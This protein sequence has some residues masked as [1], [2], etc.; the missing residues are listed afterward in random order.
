M[1]VIKTLY[2]SLGDD[3]FRDRLTS[4]PDYQLFKSLKQPMLNREEFE[5]L[6]TEQCEGFEK[7]MYQHLMQHYLS[8]RSPYKSILLFHNLGTGKTC[9]SITIAEAFLK[10]HRA[11]D[12]P[13]VIVVSTGTLQKSYEGQI[14]SLSQKASLEALRE[15]CTGDYYMRLVGKPKMPTTEQERDSLQREIDAKIKQ[16][17]EFVTYQKFASK[18]KA[19]DKEDKLDTLSNKV[20]I[21][22][23]AHNLR[24]INMEQEQQQK[25]LTRHLIRL[26]RVGRNNR[27]VLLSATPMYNEPDEILW[28]LSLL[29]TNDRRKDMLNPE[30]LPPLY[31]NGKIVPKMGKMLRQLASEYISYVRGNMPFT[32]P[33]RVS[34]E[35]LGIPVLK[36]SVTNSDVTDP[37]W[38]TYY[39]DGLVPTPLG[40]TQ[41]RY[42]REQMGNSQDLKNQMRNKMKIYEQM[43]CIVFNGKT[44]KQWMYEV[45]NVSYSPTLTFEYKSQVPYLTPTRDLLGDIASKMQRICEFIKTSTGIVVV[46]ANYNSSGVVPLALALEHVGFG[47]HGG[48]K[49]L[50]KVPVSKKYPKETPY[51]Y[52]DVPSPQ[53]VILSGDPDVM[54]GSK[55][56]K[57]LLNDIN[58]ASNVD[59]KQV[60]VVLITP[61][62]SEGLTIKNAREMHILTPWYNINSIEQVIGRAIRTCSH[63]LKPLEERNVTVYWHTSTATDPETGKPIDTADLHSYRITARKLVQTQ[64]V[65]NILRDSAWDCSLMK[66]LNY[67]PQKAFD[68]SIN[69]RTSQGVLVKH[70]YGDPVSEEPRC[71]DIGST[72]RK[73]PASASVASST[74]TVT[75]VRPDVYA[76]VIPTLQARLRKYVLRTMDDENTAMVP[77]SSLPDILRMKDFPE[78]VTSTIKASLEKDGFL[79]GYRVFIHNENLYVVPRDGVKKGSQVS[80]QIQHETAEATTADQL[81]V[82]EYINNIKDDSEATIFVYDNL[83]MDLWPLL[84]DMIIYASSDEMP[85]WMRR[86]SDLLYRSG[87][88]IRNTE[89]PSLRTKYKYIGYYD[90]FK[91]K[92]QVYILD[93]SGKLGQA[94]ETETRDIQRK[95]RHVAPPKDG[96]ASEYIGVYI[97]Y[98]SPKDKKMS[99]IFKI[100][101]KGAP[102]RATNPGIVC[103]SLKT[104]ELH[105]LWAS[106][107]LPEK[108]K[109]AKKHLLCSSVSSAML[110]K[111]RL[112]I[113]PSYKPYTKK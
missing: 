12:E 43:D 54:K 105:E 85:V 88:L 46:Y 93:A 56:I 83:Y 35:R 92:G 51:T 89:Y 33:V 74:K 23:E 73:R 6:A 2:P 77:V 31:E 39:K 95:R 50:H 49:M 87:A 90:F 37:A 55:S 111:S 4:R 104:A 113:P 107:N 80:I 72:A 63:M 47:R 18:I 109:P 44:G 110:D 82:F 71:S 9:S 62:A 98:K 42:I 79:S 108:L 3:D 30:K 97:P 16:R 10:D 112:F 24:D 25:D 5:L 17:Y 101:K 86:A 102:I 60:K 8:I 76:D 15:Q 78:V 22:D 67:I 32:F 70:H 53:Y 103:T 21:I 96:E 20:I 11:G 65:L 1:V 69:M 38:P 40:A 91:E 64:E 13:S 57:D 45:F 36:T 81:R 52:K 99:L 7:T 59:G 41:L 28:L 58:S 19:L 48:A 61:V 106:L 29:C 26:L 68:F 66:D 14:F 94:S 84:A 34:P 75:T 100:Y 27:L